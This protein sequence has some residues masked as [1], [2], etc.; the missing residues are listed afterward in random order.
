MELTAK[1]E[2]IKNSLLKASEDS[3]LKVPEESILDCTNSTGNVRGSPMA[4]LNPVDALPSSLPQTNITS[5]Y[6]R[7]APLK[8]ND[9]ETKANHEKLINVDDSL[10]HRMNVKR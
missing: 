6:N 7:T 2:E 3:S 9:S 10:L 4:G 8:P 1:L 5:K